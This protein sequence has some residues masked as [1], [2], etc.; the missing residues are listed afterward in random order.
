MNKEDLEGRVAIVSG[1]G[2]GLGRLRSLWPATARWSL[3]TTR[4]AT[5]RGKAARRAEQVVWRR[6]KLSVAEPPSAAMTYRI[7]EQAADLV[8]FALQ[9]FGRL[10]ILVNNAGIL[11]GSDA[12]PI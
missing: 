8:A 1:A 10:D 3:S 4:A 9:K 11:A 12:T 5:F 2:R 6:S 7:V